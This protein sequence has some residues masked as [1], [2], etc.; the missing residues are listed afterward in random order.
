MEAP[1][2][3]RQVTQFPRL[4]WILIFGDFITRGSFYMVWPFLAVILYQKFAISATQVGLILSSAAVISVL[5]GFIGGALS[6]NYGRQNVM[7]FSGTMYVVSFSILAQ[8]DSLAGYCVVITCCSIAKAIWD[9]PA[10]ALIGDIVPQTSVREL[11]MQARYFV[12]NVGAAIGPM[13]GVWFGLTGQQSS[14]YI[15]AGCFACLLVLLNWGFRSQTVTPSQASVTESEQ[16]VQASK[17]GFKYTLHVL[18]ADRLL[19]CLIVANILCMF[20]YGQ[21]DSSLI[22]YLTRAGATDLVQLISSMIFTNAMV[23]ISCQFILLKLLGK[24]SLTQRIQI[25]L[26]MLCLSQIWLA[27]NST[28]QYWS[29][30]GAIALMSLAEAILFPSM[31]VHIDR[32]AP[33]HLRGAYFG[34]ASMYSLGFALAPLGGGMLLDHLGGHWLFLVMAILAALVIALYGIVEKL[35]R[36]NFTPSQ[37]P[38]INS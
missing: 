28:E 1:V 24:F 10:A 21:M 14:F 16:A 19:Q 38:S 5:V 9:A 4:M 2:S 17:V 7:L 30:L 12:V 27:L 22:Q 13:L 32:L 33:K 31:N 35:P 20:I 37:T 26:L 34:A 36:P 25:G 15:T 29:W 11:A 3:L 18:K 23:I 8:V 6:D